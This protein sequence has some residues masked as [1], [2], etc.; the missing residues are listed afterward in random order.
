MVNNPRLLGTAPG[1]FG[2]QEDVFVEIGLHKGSTKIFKAVVKFA[3]ASNHV[4]LGEEPDDSPGGKRKKGEE[5]VHEVLT[6]FGKQNLLLLCVNEEL[7]PNC[8]H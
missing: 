8:C 5:E 6:C 4:I 1:S 7:Q 2:F 3:E